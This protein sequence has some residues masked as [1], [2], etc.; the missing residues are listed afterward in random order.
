MTNS[1]VKILMMI[2]VIAVAIAITSVI[3]FALHI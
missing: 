2:T 3:I 1:E